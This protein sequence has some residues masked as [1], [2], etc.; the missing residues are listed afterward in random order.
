M[1]GESSLCCDVEQLSHVHLGAGRTRTKSKVEACKH[2][3]AELQ[4]TKVAASL[5]CK[6]QNLSPITNHFV[7]NLERKRCHPL[8]NS[9]PNFSALRLR[10]VLELRV[11]DCKD[12]SQRPGVALGFR[13]GPQKCSK[14][15][16]QP[17]S[18]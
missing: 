5:P 17:N 15:S 12:L 11:K 1:D 7:V 16:E 8:D 14:V 6:D 18:R 9:W 13:K 4:V 3:V 2:G 10:P